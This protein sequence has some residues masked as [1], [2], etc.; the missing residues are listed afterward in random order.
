MK[1]YEKQ[2]IKLM[3]VDELIEIEQKYIEE[4]Q[5]FLMVINDYGEFEEANLNDDLEF[6]QRGEIKKHYDGIRK[7]T[8][9]VLRNKG[10]SDFEILMLI[11]FVGN[12][13]F[14]FRW[15]SY[16]DKPTPIIEMCNGLDSVLDKAPAFK[17]DILYRSCTPD[18]M[19]DFHV[20]ETY[21][22]QH[23]LTTTKDNW[24]V[25]DNM[26][27]ITPKTENTNARSIYELINKNGE[28][29]VTF[30]KGT[31]FEIKSIEDK[32]NYKYF[33]LKEI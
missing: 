29:Q 28:G 31:S 27:I 9:E 33:Y 16:D 30:K 6:L 8:M 10:L 18:D 25:H 4:H 13:S 26:Y 21:T 15:Y 7:E 22:F 3:R 1:D 20:G 19:F 17:G 2:Q 5:D 12:L 11:C 23:Y 24:A 32:G 14:A